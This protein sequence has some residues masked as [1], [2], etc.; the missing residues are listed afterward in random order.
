MSGNRWKQNNLSKT[1]LVVQPGEVWILDKDEKNE[2]V[3]K[4]INLVGRVK[5]LR[6]TL[7]LLHLFG[8]ASLLLLFLWLLLLG[9]CN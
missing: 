4:D 2:Q 5:F 8:L 9:G 7:S 1:G 3:G 6:R